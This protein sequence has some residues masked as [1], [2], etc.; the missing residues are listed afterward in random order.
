MLQLE[1]LRDVSTA[2]A[3]KTLTSD[4]RDLQQISICVVVDDYCVNGFEEIHRRWMDLNRFLAQLR[5]YTV[6]DTRVM[7]IKG[8]AGEGVHKRV[9]RLFPEMTKRGVIK[10]EE[11]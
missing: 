2:M 9:E 6:F 11:L 5:E 4:H 1:G 8:E 7:Y 10:L 3:L